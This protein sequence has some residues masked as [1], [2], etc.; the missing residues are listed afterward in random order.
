MGHDTNI[1]SSVWKPWND[2]NEKAFVTFSR[3]RKM[4]LRVFSVDKASYKQHAYLYTLAV[5]ICQ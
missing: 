5:V 1:N 3:N 4:L 2:A